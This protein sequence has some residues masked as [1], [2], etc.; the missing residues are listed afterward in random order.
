MGL[1]FFGRWS[2]GTFFIPLFIPF[3]YPFPIPFISFSYP[4]HTLFI[5][6]DSDMGLLVCGLPQG[7]TGHN[8]GDKGLTQHPGRSTFGPS[9]ELQAAAGHD[10][11]AYSPAHEGLLRA[12]T[13]SGLR[14]R[15]FDSLPGMTLFLWS[16]RG[17]SLLDMGK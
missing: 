3:S 8:P 11:Y 1:F 17:S 4:F 5:P 15:C 6:L 10:P 16:L 2:G 12:A 9:Q 13:K 7:R 14:Q